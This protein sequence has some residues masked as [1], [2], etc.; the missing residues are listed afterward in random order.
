MQGCLLRIWLLAWL[1][2]AAGLAQASLAL[3]AF[4]HDTPAGIAQLKCI[5]Q[6]PNRRIIS[7]GAVLDTQ[8]DSIPD[9][10]LVAAHGLAGLPERCVM[11]F[12]GNSLK[13]AKIERGRGKYHD[14][15]WAVVTL[16]GRF[17]EPMQRLSWYAE[18]ANGWA[19]FAAKGG[20]ISLLRFSNGVAGTPC[21][22]R[23]PQGG[24]VDS[25]DSRALM[26]SD[27]V[28]IPGMSGAPALVTV[29]GVPTIMGLSIGMRYDMSK[30]PMGGKTRANLIRL[31]DDAVDGAIVRAVAFELQP[32]GP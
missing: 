32:K 1:A 31:V 12:G 18:S 28:S 30:R 22:I 26:L 20:R 10:A 5:G 25:S 29:N 21:D 19:S 17:P 9:I 24:M 14:G 3:E 6:E 15:D 2:S 23:I 7:M 13:V 16:A 8:F 27:C 11:L 4:S